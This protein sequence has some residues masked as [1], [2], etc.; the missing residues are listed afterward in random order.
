MNRAGRRVRAAVN[1][2]STGLTRWWCHSA[3]RHLLT[4]HG[5]AARQ[6]AVMRRGMAQGTVQ[7]PS[8][9]TMTA[10]AAAV[11]EVLR[12]DGHGL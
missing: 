9:A 12:R 6:R 7:A 3:V 5:P 10:R 8:A 1:P 4:G 11:D 2:L